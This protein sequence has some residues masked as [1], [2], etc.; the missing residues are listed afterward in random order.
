VQRGAVTSDFHPVCKTN[1]NTLDVMAR[2]KWRT[3]W[4]RQKPTEWQ[5]LI[6]FA[7]WLS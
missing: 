6:V 7:K 4:L 3:G 5:W 2:T 1:E